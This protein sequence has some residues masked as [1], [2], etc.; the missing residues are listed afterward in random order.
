MEKR[1]LIEI[2]K[3][4]INRS[5]GKLA[6]AKILLENKKPDDAISRA[7]YAAFLSVK[8]L[9]SLLGVTIKTHRDILTMFGIK[10]VKEEILPAKFGKYLNK[11]FDARE[12]SDYAIMVYYTKK[13]AEKYIQKAEEIV[14]AIKDVIKNK[15][16]IDI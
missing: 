10:I 1:E 7:Y 14:N 9:L 5:D 2:V 6:S 4:L 15:F 8:A 13:D 16:K 3:Q 12:H 11:L